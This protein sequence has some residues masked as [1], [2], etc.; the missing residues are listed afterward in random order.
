MNFKRRYKN[1]RSDF[2]KE[3]APYKLVPSSLTKLMPIIYEALP[4]NEK[5]NFSKYFTEQCSNYIKNSQKKQGVLATLNGG[6][7]NADE[8]LIPEKIDFTKPFYYYNLHSD[9]CYYL[10][11]YLRSIKNKD[12]FYKSLDS[13]FKELAPKSGLGFGIFANITHQGDYN[14]NNLFIRGKGKS[15]AILKSK[16]NGGVYVLEKSG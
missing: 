10:N 5:T 8:K 7:I 9:L 3:V 16:Y 4:A 13:K 15:E 12:T 6:N 2:N 1:Q 11:N 14:T